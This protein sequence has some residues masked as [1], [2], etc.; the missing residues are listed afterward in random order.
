MKKVLLLVASIIS[1]DSAQAQTGCSNCLD[2]NNIEAGV[3]PDGSLFWDF[4]LGQFEVPKGSGR[5]TIFANALWI[6]GVDA[7]NTLKIAGQTY[8]QT[9]TDF[10]PGPLDAAA[11]TDSTTIANFNRVWKINQCDIDT[12]SSWFNAGASG[13]NPTDV[14]AMSTILDWPAFSPSG[15]PL[16][17]FTDANSNGVYDPSAGDV[18]LIKGDQ[19]IFFVCNDKGGVHSE[20]GGASIGLEIQAMVYAYSCPNDSAL[21]NTIFTSYNIINRSSF[22]LD[23]VFI[24]NWTDFDIGSATDDFVGCDVTRGAFYA[25]NGDLVDDNPPAGQLAYG[26]NPPAQAVVFL[27]GPYAAPNGLDDPAS[28]SVNGT[29]YGDGIADN[30]RLGMSKFMYY[31]NDNG[32]L[33]NPSMATDF[34]NYL[35]GT[36]KNGSSMT[37]GGNGHLT[38]VACDYM[39]PGTSDPLGFGTNLVPQP[40]WDET[41]AGNMPADRRGVG[42]TGPFQLQPGSVQTMDFAYVYG[43]ATTGGN[44]ASVTVM[45][46]RIDSVRS[47]FGN[48]AGC[49]CSGTTGISSLTNNNTFEIYPNPAADNIIINYVAS[50][51]NITANIYDTTGKLVKEIKS[52][53]TGE[54][55]IAVADL[56]N[57]LYLIN[58]IDG[59]TSSTKRFVKQ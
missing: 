7:S 3:N 24:G 47:K 56:K 34:Y 48:I 22:A 37:Y 6:G 55:Q 39:F 43:R 9:G 50:S 38:G 32:I 18:P 1:F 20:T 27:Q 54:N 52:L 36:W 57:G 12:Y 33:G 29:N 51:K 46:E 59:N 5:N 13:T 53:G 30:E 26:A 21:Y 17:P 42:S 44:L 10:W 58:I 23:S 15:A 40:A 2:I 28:S 4:A 35:T 11:A 19:A 31:I 45:Q 49:G 8:R 41:T 16:A 14:T 25:Y